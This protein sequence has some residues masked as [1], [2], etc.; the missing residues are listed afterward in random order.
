MSLEELKKSLSTKIKS[1]GK[2]ADSTT[3]RKLNINFIKELDR[4]DLQYGEKEKLLHIKTTKAGEKIFIQYPGKE[5]GNKNED[6]IKPW[7]FRPKI[8]LNE[9]SQNRPEKKLRVVDSQSNKELI[10]YK[11]QEFRHLWQTTFEMLRECE[12][13]HEEIGRLLAIVLYRMA[14]LVDTKLPNESTNAEVKYLKYQGSNGVVEEHNNI[15]EIN[16]WYK[17]TPPEPALKELKKSLPAKEISGVSLEAFLY[18]NHLLA[19]NEDCKYFYRNKQN[20]KG[21]INKTGRINTLLTLVSIIGF[22]MGDIRLSELLMKFVRS[23]GIGPSTNKEVRK[24]C[25]DYIV[26]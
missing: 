23:R 3:R 8:L 22:V 17:Y 1:A 16:P 7:D 15:E 9:E 10:F 13:E 5:S 18:Y 21:W 11:D 24:I 25:N 12:G 14:F 2:T 20:S 26:E 19:W 6:K 4:D